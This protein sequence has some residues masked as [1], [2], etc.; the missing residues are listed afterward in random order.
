MTFDVV[1]KTSTESAYFDETSAFSRVTG[2]P[3]APQQSSAADF[4]APAS[5]TSTRT[6]TPSP[7]AV[8]V[9]SATVTYTAATWYDRVTSALLR[10]VGSGDTL[11]L[12]LPTGA[13]V[14]VNTGVTAFYAA[15]GPGAYE[16][17]WVIDAKAVDLANINLS[18]I[19]VV[20]NVWNGA[21][22]SAA[23]GPPPVGDGLS[24]TGITLSKVS[25][26][27]LHLTYDNVTCAGDHVI[28]LYGGL[29]DFSA[30]AGDVGA[31]CNGGT[32]GAADFDFA[33]TNAWFNVLWVDACG[34]AGHPG[35][36]TA[37]PR[38]WNASGACASSSDNHTQTTCN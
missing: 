3:G 22:C 35:A 24:G 2:G 1:N 26:D 20:C 34:A 17:R 37:G 33:G 15:H 18:V 36:A 12:P 13:G 31:G 23:A 5:A 19:P 6:L 21:A 27:T 11:A 29:G 32:D 28:V 16:M 10:H 9:V 7:T 30:Y 25:G 8:N 38:T 14:P 4:T